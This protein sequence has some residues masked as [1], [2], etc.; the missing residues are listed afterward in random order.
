MKKTKQK[1]SIPL[2]LIG[3][4]TPSITPIQTKTNKVRDRGINFDLDFLSRTIQANKV[5][6][7]QHIKIV[8]VHSGVSAFHYLTAASKSAV[9]VYSNE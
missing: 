9:N 4:L 5:N 3:S 7:P 2:D 6:S 1:V 8:I